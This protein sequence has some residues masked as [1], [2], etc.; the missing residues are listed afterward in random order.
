VR[1][2]N[3]VSIRVLQQVGVAKVRR[4][5][6]RFGFTAAE[7]P[8]NLALALGAG[9]AT[10]LRLV[11]EA[12]ATM[13]RIVDSVRETG[14]LIGEIS[15]AANEQSAGVGLVNESVGELDGMTQQN[16]ALVE[17]SA[18]AALSLKDQAERL[19][20]AVSQFEFAPR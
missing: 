4:W 6:E 11:G 8:D 12:G 13:G 19:A 14:V 2:K 17:Q 10:P 7:Q 18:A 9:S 3:L 20:S 1:S 15:R 16:A 5:G